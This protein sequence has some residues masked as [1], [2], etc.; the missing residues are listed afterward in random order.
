MVD[1]TEIARVLALALELRV[2]LADTVIDFDGSQMAEGEQPRVPPSC[3]DMRSLDSTLFRAEELIRALR[4]ERDALASRVL[5]LE[6]GKER[7]KKL[8]EAGFVPRPP[9]PSDEAVDVGPTPFQGR[10]TRRE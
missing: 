7:A 8:R 6:C 5:E 9:I 2:Y 10:T 3:R 4:D 1:D